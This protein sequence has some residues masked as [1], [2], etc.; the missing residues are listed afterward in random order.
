MIGVNLKN[1]TK[2]KLEFGTFA[3]YIN[4]SLAGYQTS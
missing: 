4:F 2:N 1:K 3:L